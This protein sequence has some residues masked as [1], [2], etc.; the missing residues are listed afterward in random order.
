[1][2]W[3]FE[4]ITI[5]GKNLKSIIMGKQL[6]NKTQKVTHNFITLL[7]EFGKA[8]GYALSH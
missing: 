2:Y 4:G 7:S 3:L 8:A 1:M 6:L 5:K